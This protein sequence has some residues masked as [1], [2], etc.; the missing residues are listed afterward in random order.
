MQRTSG[1]LE[2]RADDRS[3][4]GELVDVTELIARISGERSD[5]IEGTGRHRLRTP[6]DDRPHRPTPDARRPR[7]TAPVLAAFVVLLVT[8]T[9]VLGIRAGTG[10]DGEGVQAARVH[11]WTLVD[12]DEFTDG[13][14]A[15]WSSYDGASRAGDGRWTPDAIT[16]R[17]GAVVIRG[18]A[19]SVTGGMSWRDGRVTGRWE[20]RARF[21]KGYAGYRPVLLL[22][23]DGGSGGG[24]VDFADTTSASDSVSFVLRHGSGAES[25]TKQLDITQWHNYAVEVTADRVTGYV[26]GQK[27]FESTDRDMLPR[28]PVHPAIQLDRLPQ[29]DSPEPAE[30]LVDWMRVY[31]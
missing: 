14:G 20:M 15:K 22:R 25:A 28:G 11:G 24:E 26:D 7:R 16:V 23:P 12:R 5:P 18:D 4:V 6:A 10:P 2:D 19:V 21:P 31:G 13:I 1:V 27:W 8:A 30:L 29:G 3:D 17:D 9:A